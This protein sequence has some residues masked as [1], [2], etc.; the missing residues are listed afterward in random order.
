MDD[1]SNERLIQQ[2]TEFDSRLSAIKSENRN[3]NWYP[4]HSMTNI[5]HLCYVLPDGIIGQLVAGS[6]DWR[7]LDVGAADGDLG[8]FFE[9]CG[10]RIDFLDN[11]PTNYND[12]KGIATLR[13]S[14]GSNAG[15]IEQDVDRNITLEGQ[16][17]FALALGLLYHLRNPMAFMMVLAEHADRMVLSTRVANHLPD[18][19]N[20]EQS[21][22]AYL[23][24]CRESNNDP[25]NY[26]TF[27]PVG[28]ET[29]LRR[30][31]WIVK[32][33]YLSGAERS[34]PVDNNADQRMFVYC[35]RVANW[36]DLGKHHDF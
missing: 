8:Y 21:S 6:L 31:G 2:A 4:Y 30:C 33:S 24:R 22:V 29:A 25:T 9:S 23:S 20:I 3:L 12:C 19:V 13:V 11:P 28:L 15:L 26:W 14:L 18:G 16:Y 7:V 34:N 35:E 10:S 27:S 5:Q 32:E 17:D 1:A 36:Q